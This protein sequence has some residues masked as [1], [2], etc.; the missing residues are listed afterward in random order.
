MQLLC[1]FS[2][3]RSIGVVLWCSVLCV[4]SGSGPPRFPPFA[5]PAS[6][7]LAFS[8]KT[9]PCEPYVIGFKDYLLLVDCPPRLG[10][11]LARP[12]A[13]L[14]P[15]INPAETPLSALLNAVSAPL[16]FYGPGAYS[17]REASTRRPAAKR[18]RAKNAP[19]REGSFGVLYVVPDT[20][21]PVGQTSRAHW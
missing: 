10:A 18:R 7:P 13:L 21:A 9:V 4:P 3:G 12:T 14:C 20:T 19:T 11:P 2:V 16:R 17:W 8:R 1:A 6:L 5:C 15:L